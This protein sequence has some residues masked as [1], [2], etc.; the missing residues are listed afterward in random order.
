[1]NI[2]TKSPLKSHHFH[3]MMSS[4]ASHGWRNITR[5]S[6]GERTLIQIKTHLLRPTSHKEEVL[7][8]AIQVK[9][10]LNQGEEVYLLMVKAY[11]EIE[12]MPIGKE[13]HLL[14]EF[15]D[16]FPKDLP[17]EL[18]PTRNID[19]R[20][21]LIDNKPPRIQPLYRMSPKELDL[22]RK[23]LD[24]LLEKG[25]I[26]PS[27]SPFGS[28]V[29]F[30]K[31]KDGSMRLCIDY[32]ALNKLTIK[33][34]YP[35]PRI[36]GLLD[37]LQGA[38]VFSKIDLRSGYHQVRIH[39][40]DIEKTAFRTRYGH[41]EFRVM[42][43]GLTNVPATFVNL[44]QDIFQP[45]VDKFMVVYVDDILVYSKNE[46][47]HLDHL[48]QV[49]DILRANKLYGKT[50]K[51][52]FFQKSVEFLGFIV[53][54]EG[55]AADQVKMKAISEWPRPT[56]LKEIQ[57]FLG[58]CNYYRRFVKD[59]SSI[60]LPLT[61]L[62][63]KESTL[64]WTPEAEEAFQDLKK[65]LVEAPILQLPDPD[66]E[67]TVTTDASDFAI[68]A[69]LSQK[70][71]EGLRPVAF[72]SRKLS[73]AERNYATHEKELLAMLY[74]MKKWRVYLEGR[75]FRVLTDHHSLRYIQTQPNLSRRQARWLETFQEFDFEVEYLPGKE[76]IVADALSRRP[77]L[78]VN[79]ISELEVGND[80]KEMIRREIVNDI[81]FGEVIKAVRDP[82]LTSAVTSS[83]LE[84]FDIRNDLLYY[85]GQRL[86]L[87]QGSL[88]TK[89]LQENHDI[90]VAGHQG[91]ERTYER[92]QQ[93]YYWPKLAK[94]VKSYVKSCD[95]CQRIK[96]SQ[97]KPA[98]L[99]Q[100]L[101]IPSGRWEEVSM[102][103]ITHLPTTKKGNDSI[104]VFV[105]LFSKMAHFVA[106]KATDSAPQVARIFFD[107]IFK[108]HGLPKR[109]VSDR[110][111]KFTSMFWKTLFSHLGTKLAMST[112]FHPQ[113]DGQTERAN[114]TLEDM[115]RAYVGYKQNDW[116]EKLTAAEFV[117][118]SAS[119]ASTKI[120][121]FE[122]N[123]GRQPQTP[124]TFFAASSNV[125]TTDEFLQGLENLSK[126]A[127]DNLALA[128][129]R[130][131]KYANQDRRE[132]TFEEGEYVLVSANN[133]A[134]A[135]Q[136]S[137]PSK[138]LQARFIGPYHIKKVVSKVAYQLELPPTLRIHPTFHVSLLRKYEDP[139]SFP[140]RPR[141]PE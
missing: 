38:K 94:D 95:T 41:F 61:E 134:L 17:N 121:P 23:E 21:E 104:V 71:E 76:N 53:S 113:T 70:G 64:T 91:V 36:D 115:L 107:T 16:V 2:P 19:H 124:S 79:A 7:L 24:D 119:N 56:T 48:R 12:N 18:P 8:S 78:Q 66:A 62:T 3:Y 110:D 52:A 60:A 137:R 96:A 120:S 30:V 11:D 97:Q 133:I 55:V 80:L 138:K 99:L 68:G 10:A 127:N 108:L 116:D 67:F 140:H 89:A 135:S 82:N 40:D 90:D 43:F 72:E 84:H 1:M 112:A 57:S 130:Q 32:R 73:P 114:R 65:R 6:T 54:D 87:P 42:P 126:Q 129:S 100:P 4:S 98:G 25:H 29:I 92:M 93:Q 9:K 50:S 128:K 123:Y 33:N 14:E 83:Y 81:D 136:A 141:A 51:C 103:F 122:L 31:K 46:E 35:L 15:A 102:D 45:I 139:E 111:P 74:A 101:P 59:Y 75:H 132:A 49:L 27:K 47:E 34:R 5:R 69:V 20:I 37:Q 117:Y 26:Q 131:E 125:Q 22:L 118:N 109:I 77:D 58:I 13:R 85:D 44:M 86:C 106:M 28:P 63:K 105:D 39:P 88:R